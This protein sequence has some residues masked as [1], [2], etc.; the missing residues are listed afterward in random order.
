MMGR[1]HANQAM[2]C[3][4]G[5]GAAGAGGLLPEAGRRGVGRESYAVSLRWG[6]EVVGH[7]CPSLLCLCECR[8]RLRVPHAG[9]QAE[10]RAED[11]RRDPLRPTG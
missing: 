1:E 7:F 2:R 9:G 5:A 6:E 4:G 10:K 11:R 3:G 8:L